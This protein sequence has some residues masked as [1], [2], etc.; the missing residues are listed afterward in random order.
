MSYT[1]IS[2]NSIQNMTINTVN[3]SIKNNNKD[4]NLIK[5][6]FFESKD[7]CL[8]INYNNFLNGLEQ[9]SFI[10]NSRD[11]SISSIS[12]ISHVFNIGMGNNESN[13]SSETID[14]KRNSTKSRKHRHN[15]STS[16]RKSKT[17]SNKYKNNKRY[18][19][20]Q[21]NNRQYTNT[22][23]NS[24]NT[25][26]NNTNNN[27]LNNYLNTT[28]E[29]ISMQNDYMIQ[30]NSYNSNNLNYNYNN[31]NNSSYFNITD[32]DHTNFKTLNVKYIKR[33]IIT[34]KI[35]P[36]LIRIKFKYNSRNKDDNFLAIEK[37]KVKDKI[38][39]VFGRN[40]IM[41]IN[42][43]NQNFEIDVVLKY[44]TI[45]DRQKAIRKSFHWR[46]ATVYKQI[47]KAIILKERDIDM[48]CLKKLSFEFEIFDND[49]YNEFYIREKIINEI[50]F[51]G[52]ENLQQRF[53]QNHKQIFVEYKYTDF[54][55]YYDVTIQFANMDAAKEL[56]KHGYIKILHQKCEIYEHSS[57]PFFPYQLK[58]FDY[59]YKFKKDIHYLIEYLRSIGYSVT[60]NN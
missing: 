40:K 54:K 6:D 38:K 16:R 20:K 22:H 31:H 14:N 21:T 28:H 36:L 29:T 34:K 10:N 56:L 49:Q 53:I 39:D 18:D 8:Q 46:N 13:D 25:S 24:K 44:E 60:Y 35:C 32:I 48:K 23:N 50:E 11:S 55:E 43:I 37:K 1:S 27:T 33:R 17:K 59:I 15:K 30:N 12:N 47:K 41:N 5:K 58:Y 57:T 19:N 7:E 52:L 42:L 2:N 3:Q 45:Y 51:L 9:N 4:N 26:P